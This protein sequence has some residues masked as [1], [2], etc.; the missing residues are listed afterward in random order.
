MDEKWNE[1]ISLRD[2]GRHEEALEILVS[3]VPAYR[4]KLAFLVILGDTYRKLDRMDKAISVFREAIRLNERSDLASL[5]L[6]HCLFDNSEIDQAI[7][8]VERFLSLEDS[9]E[10]R[11]LLKNLTEL[12]DLGYDSD[13]LA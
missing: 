10:H 11:L 5:A 9:D 12:R 7:E 6:A 8:E 3:L 1:A 2:H 13:D 4:R